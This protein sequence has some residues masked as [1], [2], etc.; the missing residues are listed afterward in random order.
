MGLV[1]DYPGP[2]GN[3]GT[4]DYEYPGSYNSV[5]SVAAIDEALAIAD[6][7]QQTDQVEISGPGVAVLSTVPYID[8]SN[9]TIG[10]VTYDANHIEFSARG[11]V[12]AGRIASFPIEP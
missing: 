9:F 1:A 4:T 7:S 12:T 3:A 10:G 6:F 11:S 5:M 8:D 2:A